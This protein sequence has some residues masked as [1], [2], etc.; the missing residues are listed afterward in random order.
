MFQLG[1]RS[2]LNLVGV[3]PDMIRV[4]FRAIELTPHDFTVTEGLRDIERQRKL[5]RR[6]FS[7]TL[8]SKHMRQPDGFSHAVDVM[9]VGDLNKD[10]KED[11]QD[12]S[13][14]WNKEIYTDIASAFQQAADELNVK[15]RWGG[16]FK[17]QDGEP[18]FD[19]PHFELAED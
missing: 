9:A 11:A 5:V 15:I 6:G 8:R 12:K 17:S 3:H 13:I 7:W 18:R 2:L 1:K 10:G 4:V 16:T 14:T 19:G